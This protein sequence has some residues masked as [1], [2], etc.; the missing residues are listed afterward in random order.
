MNEH[1]NVF[2]R[3]FRIVQDLMIDAS[4]DAEA[5]LKDRTSIT[6]QATLDYQACDDKLCFNPQSIPLS[7]TVGLRPL[8][9][10]RTRP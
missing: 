7:W 1:V 8:D 3:P 4:R 2:A 5:L 6:I 9:G 10:E